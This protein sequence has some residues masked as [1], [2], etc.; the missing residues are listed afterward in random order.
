MV[1][2]KE[3]SVSAERVLTGK[4]AV[5][6]PHCNGADQGYHVFIINRLHED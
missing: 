3:I 2:S 4:L 1:A 5:K 6:D